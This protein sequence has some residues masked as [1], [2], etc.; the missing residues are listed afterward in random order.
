[1]AGKSSGGEVEYLLV[2]N[3]DNLDS[4]LEKAN[5]K[6]EKSVKKSADKSVKI[7]EEKTKD[8]KKE[9]DKVVKNAEKASDDVA[10]AWEDA[11]EKAEKAMQFDVEN[12]EIDID[13]DADT[14]PAEKKIDSLEADDLSVNV[15][16][17]TGKAESAIK[18]VIKDKNVDLDVNADTTDAKA[19]IEDLGETAEDVG[20]KI[21]DSIVGGD[22]D[23]SA[24]GN[25]GGVI[26]E[27]LSG[28]VVSAVPL[29]GKIGELT[30]GL[31]GAKVAAIGAGAAAVG[32]GALAVGAANDMDSAMNTFLSTTGKST[33]E[34]ERYQSVLE[35]IYKNNYG[36][37]FQDIAS[38]MG[39][40]T[41]QLGDMDDSSLQNVTES[42]FALR[43]TFGYEIPESTRAAK[44]MMDNFGVS[45]EEAMSMIAAG[46]QNGLDYSG[47]LLDSISEYSVQFDKMGLS[48][49]DMF[50]IFQKGAESGAFNLDKVGD[51][52]KEMSI[53]VVDGSETTKQGFELLDL[54]ADEMA[55]KFAAGGDTAK[56]AFNQTLDALAAMEDPIAQNTA[57]VDLMGT[58]WEDLGPEAVSA[59]AD[60]EDGAY[61]TAD[62][63][64]QIKD[65]KYDDLG[66]Q[67][68]ELKRQVEIAVVPI[69]ESL[70]PL[71]STLCDVVLPILSGLLAPLIDLFASLLDPILSLI[72]TAITPLINAFSS[73]ISIAITPLISTIQSILVP[74]FSSSLNSMLSSGSSVIQNIIN[75]LRNL[76]DF[77]KNVFTGNWRGAWNN[78]KEIFSNAVSGL[79]S[80]FKSPINAIVDGWNSLANSIGS[81]S[82]PEWV[83]IAGGKSFS[84]PKMARLKVGLDYVPH[85]MFPAFLDEG[86]WVLTKEEAN[87]LRSLGGIEGLLSI[88]GKT[89]V[90]I[91]KNIVV[92]GGYTEIDYDRLGSAVAASLINAG[93]GFK[94]DEVVF[95]RLI[96]DLID[97]V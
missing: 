63:M 74:I 78:V 84:L 12:K 23:A 54:N 37:N 73:L 91:Q 39:D 93:V 41:R 83:P 94:C 46:A 40:V 59:L 15:D 70:I 64:N 66:S 24:I 71:L 11:G 29:V 4:D 43:D 72:S 85:D 65:V 92:Q 25:I 50:N 13:V 21:Q 58:M 60:I 14:A 7:E 86:E 82:I 26:K 61:D 80:I 62:A 31:S 47:E 45:G 38:A 17:E 79:V 3:D 68:E 6:V 52:V 75:I 48:A 97:Y 18:N 19:A 53:R 96:K 56:E 5:K 87:M 76:I 28:A 42:A 35:S 44:A 16:A 8:I 81:V 88:I 27:N 2:A 57:G 77:V 32:A 90:D 89:G 30:E 95:A 36:E 34:T 22:V 9:S 51:A 55:S 67:F 20:R 10:D 1:M 69:G 49:D 33:E